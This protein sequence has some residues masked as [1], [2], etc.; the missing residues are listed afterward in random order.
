LKNARCCENMV[1]DSK[2]VG[3][4]RFACRNVPVDEILQPMICSR[5]D[6]SQLAMSKPTVTELQLP[7]SDSPFASYAPGGSSDTTRLNP[8]AAD[9]AAREFCEMMIPIG[10]ACLDDAYTYVIS[11]RGRG[12][13]YL[14]CDTEKEI[15]LGDKNVFDLLPE[16]LTAPSVVA[17]LLNLRAHWH[18]ATGKSQFHLASAAAALKTIAKR[19]AAWDLPRLT[20]TS[21]AAV[22]LWPKVLRTS[23]S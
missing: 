14:G 6:P 9:D 1:G 4:S 19:I 17:A 15:R 7:E 13:G 5:A 10:D 2:W 18:V 23:S 22:V 16:T 8:R 3:R 12:C 20:S 11:D 21:D